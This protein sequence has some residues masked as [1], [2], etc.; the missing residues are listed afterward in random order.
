MTT[1]VRKMINS[2]AKDQNI[3]TANKDWPA[4]LDLSTTMLNLNTAY[5]A[6]STVLLVGGSNTDPT[7]WRYRESVLSA[8]RSMEKEAIRLNDLLTK[9]ISNADALKKPPA[10]KQASSLLSPT[11]TLSVEKPGPTKKSRNR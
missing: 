9:I 10:T 3:S 7:S 8:S 2:V 11:K 6:L 1:D 4:Y 5:Y